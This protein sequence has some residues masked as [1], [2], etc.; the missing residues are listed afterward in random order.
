MLVGHAVGTAELKVLT[1]HLTDDMLGGTVV[2]WVA[3]DDTLSEGVVVAMGDGGAARTGVLP[4]MPSLRS[5]SLSQAGIRVH[6]SLALRGGDL[7]GTWS[8]KKA[9]PAFVV[10]VGRVSGL[11]RNIRSQGVLSTKKRRGKA[12]GGCLVRPGS[13]VGDRLDTPA[14]E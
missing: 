7:L 6:Q 10:F 8:G 1:P 5:E 14:A 3:D 13:G 12:P 2:R 9:V 4:G 11:H